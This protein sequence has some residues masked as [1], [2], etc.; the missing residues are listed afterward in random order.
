MC[1]L[2]ASERGPLVRGRLG[3]RVSRHLRAS[4]PRTS[5]RAARAPGPPAH[6]NLRM[7]MPLALASLLV[8]ASVLAQ[9][10]PVQVHGFLSVRAIYVNGERSWTKGGF[11]R[12]DV[13]PDDGGD[14]VVNVD[15]AQVGADWMPRKWLALH[16]DGVARLEPSGTRGSRL[17]LVQAYVDVFN[18]QW[19]LR[20]GS[21]WLPTSRE[22]TEPLWTSRYTITYSALNSWIAQEVRPIGA[23]LQY[24]PNFYVSAGA[25]A[26]RGNDTMGTELSARGWTLGNRLSG[27]HEDLPLPPPDRETRPFGRDLD[28]RN[29]YS[30]RLRIQLP[31]RAKLQLAHIDNRA[32]LAA[33][34]PAYNE[35]PWRTR[36]NVVSADAG[37]MGPTTVAAE[38]AAGTT[39]VGFPGGSFTLDFSTAYALV[40]HKRGA[41]RWT[42]R[43][44][45][46]A[47][48]S[49]K[50]P[51][52]D[53]SREDGTAETLAW[54]REFGP[55]VRGGLEYVHVDGDRPGASFTGFSPHTGGSTVTL[56]VRYGF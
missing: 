49:H 22:N 20:A 24:S 10:S 35:V 8:S 14:A 23:D 33:V 25:T 7:R 18:D 15:L 41:D 55:H 6:Y 32:R 29:G 36:F 45:R 31:E 53:S 12:F 3:R 54:L 27:F 50:R 26:F 30:E 43:L 1:M 2:P 13:G 21:F 37:T 46:F 51:A 17:G 52:N 40:S 11:G 5:G 28:G 34:A 9:P 44:E 38:W 19:A 56:E 47:T 16:A 39:T 42:V 4:G 48:R